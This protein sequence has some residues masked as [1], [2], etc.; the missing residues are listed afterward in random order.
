MPTTL[1]QLTADV[2]TIVKRADLAADITLHTKNAILKAHSADFWLKDLYENAFS[3][4]TPA[5]QYSLDYR[6]LVPRWKSLK[7]LNTIDP[8]TGEVVRKLKPIPVEKFI[9]GYGYKRDYSF[10][11]AGDLLQIR[12]SDSAQNFGFGA[13]L[14]P[15]TTLLSAP[16]WIADQFPYAIVYE[17]ARTLFKLIGYQ[18]QEASA[19]KLVAEAMAEVRMV[20]LATVGE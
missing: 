3:F 20:G 14:Y 19:E 16:S 17:A 2:L 10:Y 8:I 11:L 18:E 12:V 13:Y 15:D 5:V 4:A 1:N 6:T 7:Y 9:D